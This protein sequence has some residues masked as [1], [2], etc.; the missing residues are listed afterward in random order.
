M[1]TRFSI[2]DVTTTNKDGITKDFDDFFLNF[3]QTFRI[4]N[5]K[6]FV[7]GENF[8]RKYVPYISAVMLDTKDPTHFNLSGMLLP[9]KVILC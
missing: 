5:F 4:R 1:G 3:Q 9:W 8:A 2:G 7:T 6:I